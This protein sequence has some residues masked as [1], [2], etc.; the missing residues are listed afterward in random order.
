[1]SGIIG[2]NSS[3][4]RSGVIGDLGEQTQENLI[5]NSGFDVWSNSGA[6]IHTGTLVAPAVDDA[7]SLFIN[8]DGDSMT[9]WTDNSGA[10]SSVGIS[11]GVFTFDGSAAYG[12]L[13]SQA[14][15][16]IKGN[17]YQIGYDITTS[18]H[19][20]EE[21]NIGTASNGGSTIVGLRSTHGYVTTSTGT[22]FTIVWEST[23]T[24]TV[25]VTF[26][27]GYANLRIDNLMM[28]EVTTS[29]R[30]SDALAMDGWMKDTAT[31]VLR[32]PSHA[33]YTKDG[34]FY[35]LRVDFGSGNEVMWPSGT[36]ST[37][38][39]AAAVHYQKFQGRTV[40]FGVWCYSAA[41]T[42][43]RL[44]DTDGTTSISH[45]GTTGWEWLELT[46]TCDSSIAY[47]RVNFRGAGSETAY[48]SQPMLVLGSSIGRGNYTRPKGE[49]VNC[50]MNIR[51]IDGAAQPAAA[52]KVRYLSGESSGKIPS[53]SKAVYCEIQVKNTSISDDQGIQ[54]GPTSGNSGM[55]RAFPKINSIWHQD[56]GW[57][58]C[59]GD[60]NIYQLNKEAGATISAL[61]V[62]A[63][64]IVLH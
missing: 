8:G 63:H 6:L 46:R 14:V 20:S 56:S 34:S 12:L 4:A 3:G 26:R 33:T 31:D 13:T 16:V 49:I 55:L 21:L 48:F 52:D 29:C 28:H 59:D 30:G 37:G 45:S 25:Y 9:G 44:Q 35:S 64:Q 36:T 18:G 11:G 42:L 47:F 57:V 51:F 1:M 15:A 27:T 60:G 54:F 41:A 40:T 17:I 22:G 5:T 10:S 2:V 61:Y 53:Q 24:G 38:M 43:V 7:G 32:Q 50:E 23:Y 39:Q 58:N 62:D 19:S